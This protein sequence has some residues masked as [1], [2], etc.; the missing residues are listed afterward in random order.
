MPIEVRNVRI[1]PEGDDD[2]PTGATYIPVEIRGLIYIYN[3]PD[4]MKLG[5]GTLAEAVTP[6]SLFLRRT[7]SPLSLS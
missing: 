5:T 6:P 1:R 2:L 3:P 7:T 4:S